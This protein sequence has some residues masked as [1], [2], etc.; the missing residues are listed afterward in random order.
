MDIVEKDGWKSLDEY[1]PP[2]GFEKGWGAVVD[3][4]KKNEGRFGRLYKINIDAG[5]DEFVDLDKTLGEQP[6]NVRDAFHRVARDPNLAFNVSDDQ[7]MTQFLPQLRKPEVMAA[8]R[9]SGVKGTR[10]FDSGSAAYGFG[11][12]VKSPTRNYVVNDAKLISILRKYGLPIS[13]AGLAAL[14]QLHPEEARAAQKQE[15]R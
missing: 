6:A 10:Y 1:E 11:G 4:F 14:S 13:A 5:P 7:K 2:K 9:D 12:T 3:E 15:K 8:L